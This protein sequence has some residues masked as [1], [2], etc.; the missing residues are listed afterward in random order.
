M[1]K[2]FAKKTAVIGV[3]GAITI[4]LGVTH[5]GFIPWVTGAAITIMPIPVIL[6]AVLEGPVAGFGVGLI[7]GIFSM[8]QAAIAPTGPLDPQFVNPLISVVP[9][10][11]IGPAAW[12]VFKLLS[13]LNRLAGAAGAGIAG[14]LTNTVLVLG[15]LGLYKLLPWEL[16]LSVFLANGLPEA[17]FAAVITVGVTAAWWGIEKK[18]KKIDLED[19]E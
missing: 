2:S 11:F 4:I 8:I 6:A 19:S 13:P 1:E 3:L 14:S 10:L 18:R 9:R 7:F 15:V 5:L 16:I 17:G 12:G